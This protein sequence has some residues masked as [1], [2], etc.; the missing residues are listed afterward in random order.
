MAKKYILPAILSIFFALSMSAQ[1]NRLSS[2]DPI[3]GLSF[4]P[5]PV[6]NGKIFITSKTSLDKD[7]VIYD[8]LG[9]AVIK[10]SVTGK[11]LSVAGLSPGVYIIKI[12][13]GNNTA[14]RKLI[15]R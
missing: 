13:E 10:A 2:G 1:E 7:V 3:E 6:S 8:V 4:Y 11:E 12:Q 5:N 9:K 15:V 14:T